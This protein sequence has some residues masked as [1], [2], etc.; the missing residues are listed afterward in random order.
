MSLRALRSTHC[1]EIRTD[2][3]VANTN[4]LRQVFIL[5][6]DFSSNRIEGS[7]FSADDNTIA[8]TYADYGLSMANRSESVS[9]LSKLAKLSEYLKSLIRHI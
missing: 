4:V 1:L 7:F 3:T 2:S 5:Y 6:M 8:R 9:N